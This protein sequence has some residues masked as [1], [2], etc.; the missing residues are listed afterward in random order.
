ME[1]SPPR[2]TFATAVHAARHGNPRQRR[3]ADRAPHAPRPRRLRRARGAQ[4]A[5]PER[6]D[7]RPVGLDHLGARDHT[8]R[9]GHRHGPL[10]EAAA[11]LLH[12]PVRAAREHRAGAVGARR[13]RGRA[14]GDG[15][16][17]PARA[18]S[19]RQLVAGAAPPGA[20]ASPRGGCATRC[21]PTP[22][23]SWSPA[24]SAGSTGTW[25]PRGE[26]FAWFLG[27]ALPAPR[28]LAVLRA[29]RA[30]ARV[31]P[32]RSA[33]P[34]RGGLRLA[35]RAVAAAGAVGLGQP[36]A[37]GRARPAAAG[38]TPPRSPR[39]P[40]RVVLDNATAMLPWPCW[41]GLLVALVALAP[42]VA[43]G[44]RA[45]RGRPGW[46]WARSSSSRSPGSRSSRT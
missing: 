37:R 8:A 18:P 12:D 17:L 43:P 44:R 23:A 28:G 38:R 26:A 33:R 11:G 14:A 13:P 21:W 42:T 5:R 22:R 2:G 46:P 6:A 27:A 10:V 9:P 4:P 34:R 7:L 35:A 45:R 24:C 1:P 39:T 31:G 19:R 30:V 29:L 16:R 20:L 25:R 41:I 40:V 3:S 36:P 15:L 32:P